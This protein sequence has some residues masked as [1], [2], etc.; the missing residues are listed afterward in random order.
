MKKQLLLTAFLLVAALTSAQ[1]NNSIRIEPLLLTDTTSIGQKIVLPQFEQ[2][3][4]K[5]S[6]VTIPVG[7]QTGWHQHELPVFAYIIEGE[8]TVELKDRKA[9]VFKKNDSF[10]EVI[11][12]QHNGVNRGTTDVVLIAFYMGGKVKE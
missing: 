4:V 7:Q 1:Y 9:V 3:E 10:A 2:F 11:Q 12:T 6:K 5:M 8:L